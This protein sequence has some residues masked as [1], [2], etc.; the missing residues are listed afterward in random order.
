[1][2][3]GEIHLVEETEWI[4]VYPLFGREH[5][6]DGFTCWCNPDVDEECPDVIVHNVE[7]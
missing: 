1:M 5:V 6:L 3:W 7:N 4:H 2:S